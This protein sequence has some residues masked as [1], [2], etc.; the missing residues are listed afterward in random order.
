[1]GIPAW[2][3]L[4]GQGR[5]S[6]ICPPLSTPAPPAP[7]PGSRWQLG[8]AA[9][10]PPTGCRASVPAPHPRRSRERTGVAL[11]WWTGQRVRLQAAGEC[12]LSQLR[13]TSGRGRSASGGV[14]PPLDDVEDGHFG[15]GLVPKSLRLQEFAFQGGEEPLAEGIVVGVAHQSH[16]RADVAVPPSSSATSSAGWRPRRRAPS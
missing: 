5:Y 2:V 8:S 3:G 12:F 14:V 16:G 11:S 4:T 15:F 1:M 13:G 6:A 9:S 10:P 7:V